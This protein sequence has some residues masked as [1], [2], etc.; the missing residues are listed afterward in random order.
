MK[1]LCLLFLLVLF[2]FFT[3]GCSSTSHMLSPKVLDDTLPLEEKLLSFNIPKVQV[4]Y[5]T[6]Y[7]DGLEWRDRL[8]ELIEGAEDYLITS[9]FLASSSE[10]LEGLY[11]ALVRK[12]ESGVRVY[13]VVDGTGPFDMTETRF[14]L[15]PLKFLRD[16]GVHLLEYSPMSAARLVSGINLLY[17]DHRK[18]LIID[19]KHLAVGGMNLNYIS[20]GASEEDLQ[21]D[22]MYEFYSP[23]LAATMLDHFVPWWNEQSWET[24]NREDFPVDW[25]AA[26]GLK[27]YD[28]FYVDQHPKSDKLSLLF[29]SLLNEAEHEIKVLPFLPFMD[30]HMMEAFRRAQERGVD[31]T[32][33]VP[34][35]KRVG[36]RKGIEFMAQDLLTMG[37]NL[38]I[39]KES[40]ASQ[41]LLHEKLMIV[42]DRYVVIG[43]TNIN[44]RS[45]NLAY[46]TA[47]VIDSPEL[48]KQVEAHFD[49]LYENTMP[50]TEEMAEKWQKFS[51]Y[52]RFVF[53]FIGG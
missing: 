23:S 39:E 9:A 22:S 8:I 24:I 43:S 3:L 47:L 25:Q 10:E 44:Y 35:D 40:D 15:I 38:R 4:T 7:Y 1:R 45:F 17:R 12:A 36:N 29:G 53:G 5:P 50:I 33:I 34:F 2:L 42:D 46:E 21:R 6:V 11:A 18:F 14:H 41:R 26:D 52:P 19:G 48:A 51:S 16:S 37:I 32:M 28:A 30:K 20:I 31:V 13:F 49:S 27:T